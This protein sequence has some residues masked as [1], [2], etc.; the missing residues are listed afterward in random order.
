MHHA[1]ARTSPRN[2]RGAGVDLG[3]PQRRVL[4]LR[5][6]P[7]LALELLEL[8]L[9][10]G[11]HHNNCVRRHFPKTRKTRLDANGAPVRI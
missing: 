8:L 10:V 1:R 11:C 2:A 9:V 3:V 4:L 5:H 6:R 7:V